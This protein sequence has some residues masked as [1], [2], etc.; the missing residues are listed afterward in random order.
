MGLLTTVFG[1]PVEGEIAT[2]DLGNQVV[3]I[4]GPVE[5][6]TNERAILFNITY[7]FAV[8]PGYPDHDYYVVLFGHAFWPQSDVLTLK[9]DG[10]ANPVGAL[11]SIEVLCSGF[12][13]GQD[14]T[15]QRRKVMEQYASIALLKLCKGDFRG[16]SSSAATVDTSDP[17]L[18]SNF[19]HPETVVA[20]FT[21]KEFFPEPALAI[22]DSKAL[23]DYFL[24]FLPAFYAKGMFP[25]PWA[26][27]P[28]AQ[29]P[30]LKYR[31]FKVGPTD[32]NLTLRPF[33]ADVS[34][35][36]KEFLLTVFQE[37]DPLE[38]NAFFRFFLYY[39]AFELWMQDVYEQNII[40]FRAAIGNA[41]KEDASLFRDK[42]QDLQVAMKESTRLSKVFSANPLEH[43]EQTELLNAC[44]QALM[45]CGVDSGK[46]LS[47]ALYKVRNRLVH[48]FNS[49]KSATKEFNDLADIMLG[50]VCS[51][52]V[53]YK[54]KAGA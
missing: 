40:S 6:E 20:I 42:L 24:T 51:I 48:G 21:A 54:S 22:K 50:V 3:H 46:N 10:H 2:I 34:E 7:P 25:S 49:A 1:K 18:I 8:A 30:P 45:A 12:V 31:K 26:I 36:Q 13:W 33:S 19:F 37:I 17:V 53:S 35:N 29:Q 38:T 5:N 43:Q 32:R 15:P 52:A 28:C 4:E 11:F 27:Q 14:D 47:D 41:E 9:V 39:Q 16:Q 23:N 44:N